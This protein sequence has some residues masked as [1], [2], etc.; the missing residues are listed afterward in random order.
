VLFFPRLRVSLKMRVPFSRGMNDARRQKVLKVM[1]V[2]LIAF[3]GSLLY[4]LFFNSG[5]TLSPD[6][7]NQAGRVIVLND[8]VHAIHNVTFSYLVQ[9]KVADSQAIDVLLPRES[10]LIDLDP[11]FQDGSSFFVYVSA[12]YHLSR[13]LT[14]QTSSPVNTIPALSITFQVPDVATQNTP[15]S[16]Q[17]SGRNLDPIPRVVSVSFEWDSPSFGNNPPIQE[18][19]LPANGES[20]LNVSATP[21]SSGEDLSFK[22]KVFTPSNVLV[23]R[24]YIVTVLPDANATTMDTNASDS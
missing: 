12:P 17:L 11:H 13:Q 4:F 22:I 18:W 3:G 7:T 9:G 2:V 19:V 16:I 23:E 24:D 8:S 6:P 1:A 15:I 20:T 21:L 14:I 10:K 5:L